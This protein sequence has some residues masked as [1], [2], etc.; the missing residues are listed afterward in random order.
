MNK[1]VLALVAMS[2]VVGVVRAEPTAELPTPDQLRLRHP[3]PQA[4][5]ACTSSSPPIAR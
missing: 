5:G 4:A 2:A 3:G 1:S